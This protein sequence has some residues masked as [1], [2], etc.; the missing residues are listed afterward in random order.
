MAN[1]KNNDPDVEA[2]INEQ[3]GSGA[4]RSSSPPNQRCPQASCGTVFPAIEAKCPKCGF[5][6][7][8]WERPGEAPSSSGERILFIAVSLALLAFPVGAIWMATDKPTNGRSLIEAVPENNRTAV[9]F[10]GF[11]LV[12]SFCWPAGWKAFRHAFKKRK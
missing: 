8:A 12:S 2:Y 1:N 6:R 10:F 3:Y 4:R 9:L 7:P 5:A 11:I